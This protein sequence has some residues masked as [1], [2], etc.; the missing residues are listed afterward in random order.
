[1]YLEVAEVG[2]LV[3]RATSDAIDPR[4][5]LIPETMSLRS[6]KILDRLAETQTPLPPWTDDGADADAT[7]NPE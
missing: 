7:Q 6:A 3:I 5:R 2:V 4:G 1:V